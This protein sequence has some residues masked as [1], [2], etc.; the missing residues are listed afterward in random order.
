MSGL[1]HASVNS[2]KKSVFRVKIGVTRFVTRMIMCLIMI[3]AATFAQNDNLIFERLTMEQGL[4]Q[5]TILCILQDSRGFIWIGTQDGL[6]R[7]DGNEFTV[8]RHDPLDSHSLSNNYI[9]SV[10]EDQQGTIWVGTLGGGLNYYDRLRDRFHNFKNVPGQ[11]STISDNIIRTLCEDRSG[12]LWVGTDNGLN[13][14]EASSGSF[15][16]YNHNK[17]NF[18]SISSD[19]VTAIFEDHSGILWV[20]TAGG[21]LNL[22]DSQAQKFINF[23]HDPTNPASLASND[24]RVIYQDKAGVLWIGTTTNGLDRFDPVTNSFIHYKSNGGNTRTLSS[25]NIW[26]ILEDR[27]NNLWIGTL[28]G[29]LNILKRE[30][31]EFHAYR[32]DPA[33]LTSISSDFVQCLYQDRAGILW[34]GTSSGGGINK[35]NPS[36]TKFK[37]FRRESNAA[38]TFSSS[39][40]WS[41]YESQKDH[42]NILWIGTDRGL[43][44]LNKLTGEITV[45]SS[46]PND[47]SSI[48]ANVIRSMYEDHTGTL[49][50]GTRTGGLSVMDRKKGAFR[51]FQHNDN[52]DNSISHNMVRCIFEDQSK[53]M[54]FG[55]DGGLDRYDRENNRFIHYRHDPA[56]P[57]TI[58]SNSIIS[59]VQDYKG[60]LW[61]GTYGEGLNRFDPATNHF[62]RYKYQPNTPGTISNN[63]VLAILEQTPGYLWVATSEGLNLFD[64]YKGHFT[65]FTV[66]DGLPN[67]F[68]YG[69]LL[70]KKGNLWM[71]TNKGVCRFNPDTKTIRNYDVNDGLQGNEFNLGATYQSRNGEMFFGG[72]NGFNAFF[73]DSVKDNPNIPP[74]VITA[75]KKFDKLVKTDESITETPSI[76][77][78]YRENFFSFEFSALDF[79]APEKNQYAY[80]LEGFDQHWILCGNRRYASYTNLDGGDY[81]FRVKGS[82]N[83]GQWNEEGV[84]LKIRIDPPVWHT[85]WFRLF[86]IAGLIGAG[87]IWYRT[88]VRHIE[89]QNKKLEKL[90]HE[91]TQRLEQKTSQLEKTNSIINAINSEINFEDVLEAI[92]KETKIIDGVDRAGVLVIDPDSGNFRFKAC[93]GLDLNELKEIQISPEEA[94]NRYMTNSIE[95]YEDIYIV[96]EIRGRPAEEKFTGL[97]LS[98]SMLVTRIKVDKSVEGY[99]ILD[100]IHRENAFDDQ[101]LQLLRNLK[102]HIKSAFIK[103]LMLEDMRRKNHQITDQLM[104]LEKLNNEIQMANE[105]I[106]EADKLKSD[107]LARMSHE[108][109]TPLNAIIGFSELTLGGM[110]GE[111]NDEQKDCIRDILESGQHLLQLINDILDISKIEAGKM[112]LEFESF[113]IMKIISSV[114]H[115]IEPLI[116]RKRQQM[117]VFIDPAVQKVWGDSGKIKQVLINLISNANKFTPDEGKITIEAKKSIDYEGLVEVS[118]ADTGRGIREEDLTIL[119]D[120]FRQ[121]GAPSTRGEKG[122]GLGLALCKRFIEMHGGTIW[123]ESE[124]G[125]GTRFTFTV[126]EASPLAEIVQPVKPVR[127]LHPP[128]ETKPVSSG[129]TILVIE[130]DEKACRLMKY[131]LEREGYS[132]VF[133]SNGDDAIELAKL[134]KPKVITLD[135]LLPHKD[136]WEILTDLRSDPETETIP[137]I[138]V[139]MLDNKD[140]GYSFE[141]DDY[142]VKPVDKE[143]LLLR[144]KDLSGTKHG[145]HDIVLIIDDDPKSVKLTSCILEEAGEKV[146]KAFNGKDGIQLARS[147][148][149]SLIILDLMM[150]EMSGFEVVDVLRKDELTYEIP[151]IVLTAKEITREDREILDGHIKKLMTKANFDKKTLI[152]EIKKCLAKHTDDFK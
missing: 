6:N 54:W 136:G 1:F 147:E 85:W 135:I 76:R 92:L 98:Y 132:V 65:H 89:Q 121:F 124:Y 20:G 107:F 58:S 84:S 108:L 77:L 103:G 126:Q 27:Q 35:Y 14:Y 78:S 118:V 128:K 46:N 55:T 71:S 4:S 97:P 143:K 72:V 140:L 123:A 75:Y 150:P 141:A 152:N 151:I 129:N 36:R 5:N 62:K 110:T 45:Y 95:I 47:P 19:N 51:R 21:G 3:S 23:K 70:D 37:W 120:E 116:E 131:Y 104:T 24:I 87:F 60:I 142:F 114:E 86:A 13:L 146:L 93:I 2:E 130:D 81:V 18:Y 57:A 105:K 83:D 42:E 112:D 91:R 53:N 90:V 113:D 11:R 41:I 10:A 12:R 44:K 40:I 122:T 9:L 117:K 22:F 101:D 67:N 79:T 32:N 29:G 28:G 39:M 145:L 52:D 31:G 49:W 111:L 99:L 69:L 63:I 30:T 61:I 139:S 33:R 109:R 127:D 68:I 96:K 17:N 38:N 133:A 64:T 137:V 73:P 88:R 138:I 102:A 119:F 66:K 149:P 7:Y 15:I 106:R 115:T 59:V 100:N 134:H 144:I 25:N 26:T 8:Y 80:M 74:I 34:I 16:R 82:N 43:N 56:N 94:E 50:I 125:K 48:S 148:R